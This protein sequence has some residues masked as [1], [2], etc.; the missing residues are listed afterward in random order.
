MKKKINY[1]YITQIMKHEQNFSNRKKKMVRE[2]FFN[3]L[4][5]KLGRNH[6]IE[7]EKEV[8]KNSK[9]IVKGL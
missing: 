4:S 1:K 8:L 2:K 9:G 7:K 3:K 6:R 5:E